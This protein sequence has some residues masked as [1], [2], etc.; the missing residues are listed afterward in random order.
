METSP[1]ESSFDMLVFEENARED[2]IHI[3]MP[4]PLVTVKNSPISLVVSS[5]VEV[6]ILNRKKDLPFIRTIQY[7][8]R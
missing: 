3:L 8:F 7:S 4:D 6:T 1:D 5:E 2:H